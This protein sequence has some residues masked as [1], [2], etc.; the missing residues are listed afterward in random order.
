MLIVPNKPM[1]YLANWIYL[2]DSCGME[3]W[4]CFFDSLGSCQGFKDG[5]A[6]QPCANRKAV[7]SSWME[8]FG[9]AAAPQNLTAVEIGEEALEMGAELHVDCASPS[10]RAE[11]GAG[12]GNNYCEAERRRRL[13]PTSTSATTR[14]GASTSSARA[15]RVR[16][17]TR[18]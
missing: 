12:S 2:P 8:R 10:G 6:F 18:R 15:R 16:S 4:K 3:T 11:K 7:E 5:R 14:T 13:L 9:F 1:F 17:S